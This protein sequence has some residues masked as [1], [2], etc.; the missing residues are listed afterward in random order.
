[1]ESNLAWI[2][3]HNTLVVWPGQLFHVPELPEDSKVQGYSVVL[4]VIWSGAREGLRQ[5]LLELDAP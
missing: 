3:I 2:L 5:V 1:M 4:K